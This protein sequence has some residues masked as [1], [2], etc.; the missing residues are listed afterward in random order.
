MLTICS[1]QT[2]E[3]LSYRFGSDNDRDKL[4]ETFHTLGHDVKVYE[5]LDRRS[6]LDEL[7]KISRN[8]NFKLYDGLVLCILS[9]GSIGEIFTADSIPVSLDKIKTYFDGTHC[10]DLVNKP[11]LFFLQVCQGQKDQSISNYLYFTK[12]IDLMVLYTGSVP[13]DD[14]I[15]DDGPNVKPCVSNFFEAWATVPGFSSYRSNYYGND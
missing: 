10:P 3:C 6:L 12:H 9:H 15:E 13:V 1:Q 8:T 14:E 2:G 4:R 5:N 11:K 7:E